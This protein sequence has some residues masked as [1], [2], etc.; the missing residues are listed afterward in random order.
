M[1]S[2]EPVLRN[3]GS[4]KAGHNYRKPTYHDDDPAQSKNQRT[5]LWHSHFVKVS[6]TLWTFLTMYLT[7]VPAA[8]RE[9]RL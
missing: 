8:L 5:D 1:H 4:N 6:K 9:S 7:K 2:S 3:K